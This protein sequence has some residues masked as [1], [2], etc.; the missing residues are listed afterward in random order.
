MQNLNASI[1]DTHAGAILTQNTFETHGPYQTYNE[2]IVYIS[3]PQD[4][5]RNYS[6]KS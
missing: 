2:D 3:N 1:L 4:K 5:E 6:Q